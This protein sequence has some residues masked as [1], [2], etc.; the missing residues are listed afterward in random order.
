MTVLGKVEVSKFYAL[1]YHSGVQVISERR[2]A[3]L[4]AKLESFEEPLS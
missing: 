3:D 4:R 2:A 1:G